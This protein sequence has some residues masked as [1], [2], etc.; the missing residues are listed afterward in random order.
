MSVL[1]DAIKAARPALSSSSVKTYASVLGSLHKKVFEGAPVHLKDYENVDRILHF[2]RDKAPASRKTILAALV[3]LT[4]NDQFRKAMMDDVHT[5]TADMAKQEASPTQRAAEVSPAEI[6]DIFDRLVVEANACYKKTHRTVSDL[7][8][9]GDMIILAL[10]SGIFIPPRRALDYTA[11]KIKDAD[12]ETDNY[13]DKNQ[14]VFNQY[15]TSKTY[16]KQT[17][18]I[19]APLKA[20]LTK[21]IKINPTDFLLFD[22]KFA[23]LTSVKLNQRL[24]RIFNG[25]KV[26]INALRHS[27]LTSKYTTLSVEQKKMGDDMHAMGSSAAMLN[28]YVKLS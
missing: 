12:H 11:F 20:I 16:G 17:V 15:K 3:V 1:V 10:L 7:L 13:L 24:N 23:P 22:S 25:R 8:T 18:A 6:K 4:S 5:F 19:P 28:T 9:I 2:L 26:A 27:F 21:Y 14:L